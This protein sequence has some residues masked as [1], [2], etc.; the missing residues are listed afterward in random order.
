VVALQPLF[1]LLHCD[2]IPKIF[3]SCVLLCS[4]HATRVYTNAPDA[5]F[6]NKEIEVAASCQEFP[7]HYLE[8]PSAQSRPWVPRW[9]GS[10]ITFTVPFPPSPSFIFHHHHSQQFASR[11]HRSLPFLTEPF[12]PPPQDRARTAHPSARNGTAMVDEV[13]ARAAEA[14]ALARRGVVTRASA[15]ALH[16][17]LLRAQRLRAA[18]APP[19]EARAARVNLAA[20]LITWGRRSRRPDEIHLECRQLLRA[21]LEEDPGDALA[22]ENLAIL[23]ENRR[24][25]AAEASASSS[26]SSSSSP[27]SSPS[28]FL[29]EGSRDGVHTPSGP[30]AGTTDA[31]PAE[32]ARAGG[33]GGTG[34]DAGRE[35]AIV[36]DTNGP[37]ETAVWSLSEAQAQRTIPDDSEVKAVNAAAVQAGLGAGPIPVVA[38]ERGLGDSD[39]A[40]CDGQAVGGSGGGKQVERG[41]GGGGDGKGSGGDG[42]G[43][44]RRWLAIGIPTVPRRGDPGYLARTLLAIARQLP[45]RADDPLHGQVLLG[46][47]LA[48]SCPCTRTGH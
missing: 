2:Y 12:P 16:G 28:S 37:L 35:W 39:A 45:T 1:T 3:P 7:S 22:R 19:D 42:G 27:S 41:G 24:L 4:I 46:L 11:L 25:R 6:E 18:G 40:Q 26:S 43:S 5:P 36:G 21:A 31:S 17:A 44:R 34:Q 30:A 9:P 20:A 47:S 32:V 8:S 10:S 14:L 15:T 38:T 29:H 13:A 48:Q 33:A 23:K